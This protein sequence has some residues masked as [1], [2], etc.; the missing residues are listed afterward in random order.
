MIVGNLMIFPLIHDLIRM[1]WI[2]SCNLAVHKIIFRNL[3]VG[4][5]IVSQLGLHQQSI[6]SSVPRHI[7][8]FVLIRHP[9]NFI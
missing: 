9:N 1:F 2:V 5:P 8:T 6:T 7:P 3:V 4:R